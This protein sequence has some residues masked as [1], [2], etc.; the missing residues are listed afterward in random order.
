MMKNIIMYDKE[1][2]KLIYVNVM[3]ISLNYGKI[4]W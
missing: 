2:K 3:E 1:N 4:N